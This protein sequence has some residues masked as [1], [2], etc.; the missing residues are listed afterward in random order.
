MHWQKCQKHKRHYYSLEQKEWPGWRT[1]DALHQNSLG[2]ERR[3]L[4]TQIVWRMREAL[5]LPLNQASARNTQWPT[6]PPSSSSVHRHLGYIEL[7]VPLCPCLVHPAQL[8]HP[9]LHV[10]WTA[11]L[12]NTPRSRH[13]PAASPSTADQERRPLLTN[14]QGNL[15]CTSPKLM[16]CSPGNSPP[17]QSVSASS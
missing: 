14:A 12:A 3:Y 15:L 16:L 10:P 17:P 1:E 13:R 6:P 9:Q 5:F 11:G 2:I 7:G 4:A 8:N